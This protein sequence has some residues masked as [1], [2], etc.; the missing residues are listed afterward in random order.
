M[1]RYDTKK[2]TIG[3][4]MPVSQQSMYQQQIGGQF[5]SLNGKAGAFSRN[6]PLIEK[7]NFTNDG[8]VLHNN[9]GDIL[10]DPRIVEYKVHISTKDRD[11]TMF[12]SPFK[13]KVPLG[14]ND[15][16]S[17]KKKFKKVKY[18][19]LDSVIMPRSIS[20]DVSHATDS[21]PNIYPTGSIYA[22]GILNS[23]NIFTTLINNKYIVLKINELNT[24]KNLGTSTLLDG[25]TFILYDD[26]SMGIDNIM[27]RPIHGTIIYPNS[28]PYELSEL[29]LSFYDEDGNILKLVDQNGNDIIN[30]TISGTNT[31]YNTFV[32]NNNNISSVQYTDK[33]T[34]ILFNFT[35][36]VIENELSITN[37][38]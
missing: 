26:G 38:D 30:S 24:S 13:V 15:Y 10:N 21:S 22:N 27:Y 11:R 28:S 9:M 34:Q 36:G 20:I 7:P 1:S 35:I 2:N 23:N 8:M 14:T 4:F 5:N 37:Y 33:V 18:I 3:G 17:I 6:Q 32:S 25:N 31:N 29:N 19:S 16:F 12:P